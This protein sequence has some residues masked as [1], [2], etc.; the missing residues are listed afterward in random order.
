[1]FGEEAHVPCEI[2]SGPPMFEDPRSPASFASNL[3]RKLEL[4]FDFARENLHAAQLRMKESYDLGVNQR[5]F[6]PGDVVYI[7]IKNL[8]AQYASKLASHWRTPHEPIACKGVLLTLRNLSN[9]SIVKM[10]ADRF[11]N[12]SIVLRHE[13]AAPVNEV[14]L[15]DSP[16]PSSA[17]NSD[18]KDSMHSNHSNLDSVPKG[19]HDITNR[20][21][22][23]RLIKRNENKDYVYALT[24]SLLSAGGSRNG[25]ASGEGGG[26]EVVQV[27]IAEGEPEAPEQQGLLGAAASQLVAP[28]A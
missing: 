18:S 14:P 27:Q 19:F 15:A 6:K 28:V 10:H 11:S 24:M 17:H 2:V 26:G 4:A 21:A 23:K 13:P 8:H 9:N 7:K 20:P 25:K 22:G 5:I 1:M 16:L 12:P 3:I